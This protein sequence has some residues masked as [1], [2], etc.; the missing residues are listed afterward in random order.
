M[1]T[2]PHVPAPAARRTTAPRAA[3]STERR[4]ADQAYFRRVAELGI[5]AAEALDHAHSL[6]VVHRDVKPANLLLDG[7]GSLWVTDFGLA[8][9]PER[10]RLTMTGDLVGTLRYMTPGAGAGQAGG[11]GPPHRRLLAGRDAVRAADAGAGLRGG[12]RQELLRQIA[13]EEPRPPR[14]INRAIPAELETI[15]LKAMEKNPADRYATA[16]ELADDLRRFLADE[17]IRARPAGVVRRLGKWRRRHQAAVVAVAVCLLVTVPALVGAAGWILGDRHARQ[18]EAERLV[19]EAL[20]EAEAAL[21]QGNPHDPKLISAARKAEA[22]LA[23]GMVREELQQRQL[24]HVG[25]FDDAR[26]A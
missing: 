6:G 1:S 21:A 9:I 16:Q 23:G 17:P 2:T 12:D 7:R 4:R 11:G 3:A 18:A 25:G 26:K 15:V 22:L 20:V 24:T 19:N 8:H 14:R 13:F 10:R 5:Q